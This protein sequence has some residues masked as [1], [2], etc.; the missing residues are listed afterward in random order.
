MTTALLFVKNLPPLC[1][2]SELWLALHISE[3]MEIAHLMILHYSEIGKIWDENSSQRAVY[4][5]IPSTCTCV[6]V[7]SFN[8]ADMSPSFTLLPS[9]HSLSLSPSTAC[10]SK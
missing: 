4:E 3:V 5:V 9:S 6:H 7:D 2:C 10:S 1:V 8:I